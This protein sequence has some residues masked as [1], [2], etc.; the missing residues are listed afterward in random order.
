MKRYPP[1]LAEV[2]SE[3]F[4]R[5]LQT[6]VY[7]GYAT[8]AILFALTLAAQRFGLIARGTW[9]LALLAVKFG[10]NSLAWLALARRKVVIEASALNI[11]ADV[12]LMTGAVYFTGGA[13]SPLVSL[14][15]VE[16]SVMALLTNVG[17]TITTVVGAFVSYALMV[18]LVAAGAL[19]QTTLIVPSNPTTGH[20]V[21]I[22]AFVGCVL[23][24]P[25]LYIAIM[26][27]KLRDRERALEAQ[28][29]A[30]I[31]ASKAKSEFT[32]NITHELRTPLHGILGMGELVEEGIYGP[33]TDK[34]RDA[35]RSI[36]SSAT[37]LLELIDSLLVVARDEARGIDVRVSKVDL[38]EVLTAVAATARM[39]IGSRPITLALDLCEGKR[40]VVETDRKMLVHIL[41]NLVANAVKFTED[42]GRIRLALAATDRGYDILVEDNG[43]GIAEEK[44]ATIFE[45]FVQEDGSAVRSHGGAGLGL[46]VVKKLSTMLE[47]TVSASSTKGRGST[48]TLSV[49][50]QTHAVEPGLRQSWP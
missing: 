8:V 29:S 1:S 23:F 27:Q 26:V 25:G 18:A 9:A 39:L 42:G 21:V 19:P 37:G 43:V 40:H 35:I 11:A 4:R 6:G 10:T 13:F 7:T 12:L 16:V 28:A 46:A 48:F 2:G 17:L 30:L 5:K 44:L 14:Y 50:R 31:D 41:V 49:P 24:A 33:V 45:P 20:V 34:Q 22:V 47:M 15:F 38:D 3:A 32:A 36:R